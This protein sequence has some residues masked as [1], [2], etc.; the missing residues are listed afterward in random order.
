MGQE[1]WLTEQQLSNMSILGTQFVA[2]SGMEDAIS[3]GILRGRPF[4]GVSIAWS[5]DL[6]S[7]IKP[8]VNF[9][10]K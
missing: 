7:I 9:K 8:L 3:S 6:N 2:R 10:H 4:G 5:P 1:I